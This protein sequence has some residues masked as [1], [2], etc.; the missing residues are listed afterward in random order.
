MKYI[1]DKDSISEAGVIIENGH[2]QPYKHIDLSGNI[3]YVKA[4]RDQ[5]DPSKAKNMHH[6]ASV[7][8]DLIEN[9]RLLKGYP[10]TAEGQKLAL[11]EVVRMVKSGELGAFRVHGA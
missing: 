2:I 7:E 5:Y 6:I 11:K 10:I 4:L 8:A 9:I 1:H 3:E